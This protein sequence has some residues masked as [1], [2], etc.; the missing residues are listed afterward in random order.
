L[1]PGPKGDQGDQGEQGPPGECD[2][3]MIDDLQNQ[4]NVLEERIAQLEDPCQKGAWEGDYVISSLP[5]LEAFRGY[6]S[7]T[8]T[9]TIEYTSNLRNLKGLECLT[10]AGRHIAIENNDLLESL[11][12]LDNLT[13]SGG[14][15]V[16]NNPNLLSLD[17][18]KNFTSITGGKLVVQNNNSLKNLEG[19]NNL[20]S[21][22][23]GASVSIVDND[24]LE[25]LS[26][27]NNLI[28][29]DGW[30]Q[31]VNNDALPVLG[32]TSLYSVE[33]SGVGAFVI[34]DNDE[35]CTYLAEDLRD[36][37]QD[38][39]GIGGNID[40]SGNKSCP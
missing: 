37:V 5:D 38:G 15:E 32:L 6:T 16:S 1:I 23:G 31:I 7:I 8:R 3:S 34:E 9:L 22:S 30:L 24:V 40:I 29:I 19:L 33:F 25:N 18:L 28:T 14:F 2:P 35:L 17:S 26:G 21:I 39:G 36:Q 27:L 13:S 20:T 11:E 12:G 4:I 10:S